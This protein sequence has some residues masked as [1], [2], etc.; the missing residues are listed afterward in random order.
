L[1]RMLDEKAHVAHSLACRFGRSSQLLRIPLKARPNRS[2]SVPNAE[3]FSTFV[4]FCLLTIS[5][6]NPFRS[7]R[8]IFNKRHN[9]L[10]VTV[11]GTPFV[12]ESNTGECPVPNCTSSC[13]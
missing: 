11:T 6:R 2:R 13:N 9:G 7:N 8:V 3:L 4:T 5:Q 1:R 12:S 10:V